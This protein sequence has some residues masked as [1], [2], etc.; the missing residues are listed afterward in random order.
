[1]Q[2]LSM[3]SKRKIVDIVNFKMQLHVMATVEVLFNKTISI[4]MEFNYK[5]NLF[6]LN[7]QQHNV[8]QHHMKR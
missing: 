2:Q 7:R 6:K 8:F 5:F 4:S 1:M 3:W